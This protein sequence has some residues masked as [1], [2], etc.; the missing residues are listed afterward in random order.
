[1][2]QSQLRNLRAFSGSGLDAKVLNFIS[3][4]PSGRPP[5]T[6][7]RTDGLPPRAVPGS[8]PAAFLLMLP[9]SISSRVEFS[10][11]VQWEF[12]VRVPSQQVKSRPLR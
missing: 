12:V 10:Q 9:S 11:G 6:Q 8:C 3:G 4:T 7:P 2:F 5:A 1:M